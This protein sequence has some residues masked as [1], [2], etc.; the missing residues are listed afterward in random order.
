MNDNTQKE[1]KTYLSIEEIH[2]EIDLIQSCI[3]R[4]SNNS[5]MLKGW[6]I[7]LIVVVIALSPEEI[8]GFLIILATLLITLSFWYLDAFFLRTEKLY[9]KLYNWTLQERPKGNNE[10]LYDL[11]PHRFDNDVE[12]TIKVM[13]SK[14][15]FW[16]YCI[17]LFIIFFVTLYYLLP[18]FKTIICKC[19]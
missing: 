14:T 9:R 18:I 13:F 1:N 17:P 2:K 3:N 6:L 19:P 16:F 8:N 11:N 5:F 10:K 4:M 15:L 12:S 7:S